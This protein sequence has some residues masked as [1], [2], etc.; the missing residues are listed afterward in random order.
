VQLSDGVRHKC[1]AAGLSRTSESVSNVKR[2][3]GFKNVRN[4]FFE[5]ESSPCVFTKY[6]KSEFSQS[7][8]NLLSVKVATCFDSRS[9]HQANY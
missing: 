9:H 8:T 7:T 4:I 2:L 1:A 5:L 3:L 6:S